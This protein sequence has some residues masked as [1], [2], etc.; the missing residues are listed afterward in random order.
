[1]F[2]SSQ[3]VDNL[4]LLDIAA[5]KVA[6][7]G[8]MDDRIKELRDMLKQIAEHEAR[9]KALA[10]AEKIKAS[11]D[12]IYAAARKAEESAA[13]KHADLS[14][15]EQALRAEQVKLE[16]GLADH[17]KKA[18]EL[19]SAKDAFENHAA[20]MKA[21]I[22]N[23]QQAVEAEQARIARDSAK[24]EADRNAFNAKLAAL[25]A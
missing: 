8:A 1:M 11:A 20:S 5:V 2:F 12:A 3:A 10:E 25:K 16:V 21:W 13:E 7:S 6:L 4:A 23:N 9:V 15:R 24:L 17:A 22:A 18:A 19:E 14:T